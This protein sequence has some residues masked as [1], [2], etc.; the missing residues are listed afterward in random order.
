MAFLS[1]LNET[2]KVYLTR[3]MLVVLLLGLSSGI[4][5]ALTSSTLQAWMVDEKV[6]IRVIGLFALVAW[7]YI[8]KI[9]WAPLMDRYSPKIL[10]RR[11]GWI[12][13]CQIAL[14]VSIIIMSFSNPSKMA[15]FTAIIAIL[16]TFFSASQDIVI[17]AYRT[18]VATKEEIGPSTSM[19]IIGYRFGYLVSNGLALIMA[20][21]MPWRSVYL[22]MALLIGL[23]IP[24]TLLAPEPAVNAARPNTLVDA[25]VKP[26]KE[27]LTRSHA[28]EILLFLVIYKIDTVI[29]QALMTPFLMGLDFT[30]TDIG[31]LTKTVGFAATVAGT[32]AAGGFMVTNGIKRSLWTFGITQGISGLCFALLAHV[33]HSYTM[34]VVAV[35]AEFFFS[36]AGNVAYSGFIM[37][38]CDKRFTATQ[39]ALFTSLMAATRVLGQSPTGFL[40]KTVGW[41]NY[42]LI[43]VLAMVPG[44]LLLLRY[45]K[46]GRPAEQG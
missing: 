43:T 15:V 24:A 20:D 45:P 33:G 30:K 26:L 34:M 12:L 36:S 46:W 41:E 28:W 5:L 37:S 32:L 2:R 29:A 19:Y 39:Y 27:F 42:F 22:M 40:Q 7:P 11:R 8:G 16:V 17:D 10:G 9:L 31:A 18:D 21:H 14:I 13:L 35:I 1:K 3:R 23:C 38:L 4:P 44:L 25:V 6:D